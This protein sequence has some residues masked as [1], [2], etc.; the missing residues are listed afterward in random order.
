MLSELRN[1]TNS[2][3][4]EYRHAVRTR[5]QESLAYEAIKTK[6]SSAIQAQVIISRFAE[7]IQT[8]VHSRLASLVTRC[9]KYVFQE[10]AY[11]FKIDFVRKRGRTEA[12][13]K[14][15]R[16]GL[17]LDDPK[18]SAGVGQVEVAAFALR[19]ACLMLSIP[20]QRRIL[21]LDE[22]FKNVNGEE[23]QE[24]VGQLILQL[25]EEME[26]QFIISSDD[27]WLKVGTVVE[28]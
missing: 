15:F 13:L 19:L 16:N 14:F 9:L 6:V 27:D 26:V 18:N 1:Q 8:A 23:Y 21:I 10:E 28:L 4:E 2:I 5:R 17:T 3:L 24:R 22:P 12:Q 7:Q 20:K 11:E 25:A